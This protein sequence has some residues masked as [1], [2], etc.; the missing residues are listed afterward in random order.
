MRNRHTVLF[1]PY[2][3]VPA[4]VV[5]GSVWTKEGIRDPAGGPDSWRDSGTISRASHY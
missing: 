3:P 2:G 5:K 4:G 1:E